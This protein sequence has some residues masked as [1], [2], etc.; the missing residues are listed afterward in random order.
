[1]TKNSSAFIWS[2]IEKIATYLVNII[3]QIVLARLL[4]PNDYAVVAML[5][6]FFSISQAFI[7]SGFA[8]TLIQKQDC[9]ERDYSSVFFFN[10][11]I[12]LLIYCLFYIGAPLIEDFYNFENLSFVTRI[13]SLNLLINSFGMI[14]RVILT[15]NLKFKSIAKI[16][17]LSSVFSAI[18][19]IVFAYYGGG[20]WALVTQSILS[21]FITV[22]LLM[23]SSKWKPV[24]VFSKESLAE[25]APFGIRMLGV[26]LFH[27]VYNNIYS[28]MIGKKFPSSDLGYYDRGKT[29]S[30]MGPVGFSDFFTR[31]LYPIQSKIQDNREA[32]ENSYKKSVSLICLLIL[33]Y[34]AFVFH[35][36]AEMVHF[37]YGP[38]WME[39]TFILS[40]LAIGYMFYPLQA[41]NMNMLQVKARGDYMLK[42]ESIKK[43]LGILC[44]CVTI[45]FRIEVVIIGW[46]ICSI[47]EY[48][49]S[50]YFYVHLY[51]ISFL[52]TFKTICFSVIIA[53]GLGFLTSGFVDVFSEDLNM[54][55]IIGAFIYFSLF[56]I[57]N[58]R[59]LRFYVKSA[60]K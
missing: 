54:R 28:L 18:P 48:L 60:L 21:S 39:C 27:A 51:K 44:V 40:C 9:T 13:Y 5:A 6:I 4:C 33:P 58:F 57:L 10:I 24:M 7:D 31:A 14:H 20:Y 49:I 1:M 12:S 26:Y 8:T 46:V 37:L 32:L 25:L 50:V 3:I 11:L 45:N 22:L 16:S 52:P 30:S 55:F 41:L 38:K 36:S 43:V 59:K 53:Y 56:Y 35:F 29:L 47:V 2:G 15:K 42:S 23:Q 34:S 19:A 17:V